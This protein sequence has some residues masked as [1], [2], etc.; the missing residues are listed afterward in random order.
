MPRCPRHALH[1]D[2]PIECGHASAASGA[3]YRFNCQGKISE[4]WVR[5]RCVS[6]TCGFI[7]S[8]KV[9]PRATIGTLQTRYSHVQASRQHKDQCVYPRAATC[10]T[11]LDLTSLSRWT[12][13]LPR[14]LQ[15]RTSPPYCGG[16]WC[17]HVAR[18]SG[19][20]ILIKEGSSATTCPM[21]P[22]PTSVL[23][24]ALALSRVPRFPVGHVPQV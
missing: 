10:P 23:G 1:H 19:P 8:P 17:C 20:R 12:P 15:L 2:S 22:D 16:L 6:P 24:R 21:V 11:A 13:A 5:R 9:G 3:H 4:K 18:C 14:V 7:T